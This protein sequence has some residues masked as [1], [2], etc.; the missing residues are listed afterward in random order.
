MTA[1]NILAEWKK[2]KYRPVYWLEGEEDYYIDQLVNYA[3]TSILSPENASFNLTVFYGRDV[4]WA[5]LINAC[6]RYP[7]FSERQVVILKEAQQMKDKDLENL[8][9]Y[10]NAPLAS[11]IFIVAHKQKTVDKRKTLYKTIETKTVHFVSKAISDYQLSE[12]IRTTVEKK[13]YTIAPKAIKLLEEHIGNDLNRIVNEID[14]IALN[15]GTK[16]SIDDADIEKYIG[17]NKEYNVFELQSAVATKDLYKAMKII[18]YFE[19]NP[20]AGPLHYILPTLYGLFGKAYAATALKDKSDYS[21]KSIFFYSNAIQEGR[22]VLTKYGNA[23]IEKTLL[24]LHNYN[25]KGIGIGSTG[26]SEAALLKELVM[27]IMV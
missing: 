16:E 6:R 13:G 4:I 14:K 18:H 5:E 3:E 24:L 9:I 27:K 11:T 2:N 22:S 8:V 25:L 10:L 12:W 7:M 21:L 26:S 15:L 17:I 23:G 19:Q 1:E 20:K